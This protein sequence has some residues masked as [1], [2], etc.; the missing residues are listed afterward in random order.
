[1]VLLTQFKK[2]QIFFYVF[3]MSRPVFLNKNWMPTRGQKE[4]RTL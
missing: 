1:M 3:P 4:G 2:Q